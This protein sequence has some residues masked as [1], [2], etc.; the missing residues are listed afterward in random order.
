M[1]SCGSSA[2]AQNRG[3]SLKAGHIAMPETAVPRHDPALPRIVDTPSD[4]IPE[5]YGVSVPDLS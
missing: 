2:D 3:L 5:E 4:G 1:T